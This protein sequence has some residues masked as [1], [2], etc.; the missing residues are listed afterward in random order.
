MVSFCSVRRMFGEEIDGLDYF[1]LMILRKEIHNGIGNM[2]YWI[3]RKLWAENERL[4]KK[5][6]MFKK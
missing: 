5:V 2:G 4:G 3:V 6:S 1:E